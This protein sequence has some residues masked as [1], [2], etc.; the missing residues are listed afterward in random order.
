MEEQKFIHIV[1]EWD[2]KIGDQISNRL[3][4]AYVIISVLL[5]SVNPIIGMLLLLFIPVALAFRESIILLIVVNEKIFQA[6]LLVILRLIW[7]IMWVILL[8]NITEP[9]LFNI[10]KIPLQA[11]VVTLPYLYNITVGLILSIFMIL[12]FGM[13]KLLVYILSK[14]QSEALI[15]GTGFVSSSDYQQ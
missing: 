11:T 1:K 13:V 3:I 12:Y 14:N 5:L 6:V 9:N 15:V 7:M 2:A 4:I 10:P 8:Y